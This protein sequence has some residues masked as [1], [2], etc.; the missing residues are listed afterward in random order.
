MLGPMQVT[1]VITNEFIAPNE[2]KVN[3]NCFMILLCLR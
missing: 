3:V 1:G 2:S